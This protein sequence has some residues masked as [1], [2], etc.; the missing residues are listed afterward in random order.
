MTVRTRF[1]PSPTGYLHVGGA[2]TALFS[3]LYARHMGGQFV[4]RV[5]DTD[6]ERSTQESVA[7]ILDG[8][9]WLGIDIDEGPVYQT[10]RLQR[11]RTVSDELLAQDK[12]YRCDC[13]RDRLQVLREQQLKNKEKPRYDGFCRDRD[14]ADIRTRE[15]VVRF[16]NPDGGVVVFDDMV[17]GRIEINNN[18]LD[19]LV[20]VRSD[21]FPTYNFAVVVDDA[22]MN[23]THVIRGDDHINNTPRQINLFRAMG[24][25]TPTFGHVPM[26]LG[27]DGQRLS[28]RHGAVNVLQYRSDGY[29][30]EAMLNYL[31][32]LGWSQ[33]DKELFSL[34][35]M[36]AGFDV[37]DVNR[38]AASFDFEKLNWLNQTY[39]KTLD[40]EKLCGLL[41]DMYAR[42]G[43]DTASGPALT[44]IVEEHRERAKTILEL[45]RTTAMYFS[46]KL[47]MDGQAAKKHLRPVVL[48]ALTAL[49]QR[50]S[51]LPEWR[52]G[53]LED[54]VKAVADE[55]ELK[56]G[57]I[58]Q[59]LRVAVTGR[60]FS[61]SI[62]VTLELIGRDKTLRRMDAALEYLTK[63]AGA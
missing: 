3:W 63:R 32:R 4:L 35:E 11:Y 61:P 16:R 2:R 34:E 13:P 58:D 41:A 28:K 15:H 38:A 26:I 51:E 5:E 1:A 50:L 36:V 6:Q 19:D 46:P 23:I 33:G 7:S 29:L 25:Q 44:G 42:L 59:P 24:V 56:L 40:T 48:P 54:T 39:I 53:P 9:A 17:R 62:D 47:E 45:A 43:V 12:A 55:H 18:E 49:R 10:G 8:L 20:M 21:G 60:T 30:P 37:A 22:E 31:V 52:R 27:G 57:K 14:Q